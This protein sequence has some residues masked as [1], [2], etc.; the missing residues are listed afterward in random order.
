MVWGP[1]CNSN[2]VEDIKEVDS[3]RYS[4]A[5]AGNG[6]EAVEKGVKFLSFSLS[7]F[8]SLESLLCTLDLDP[9][10]GEHPYSCHFKKPISLQQLQ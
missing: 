6:P 7:I 9:C 1:F 10:T 8:L 4:S 2:E 3:S 5:L